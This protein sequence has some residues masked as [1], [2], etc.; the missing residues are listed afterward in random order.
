MG[1]EFQG[2][3]TT[4]TSNR[5]A[6]VFAIKSHRNSAP[7][8]AENG[9]IGL[10]GV[11]GQTAGKNATG[12]VTICKRQ[13]DGR[14]NDQT[15]RNVSNRSILSQTLFAMGQLRELRQCYHQCRGFPNVMRK[16]QFWPPPWSPVFS[17]WGSPFLTRIGFSLVPAKVPSGTIVTSTSSVFCSSASSFF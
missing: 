1:R 8:Q 9:D 6:N 7:C 4:N 10:R 11:V 12:L 14:W 15:D 16:V 5:R 3:R 13:R 2:F 17:G